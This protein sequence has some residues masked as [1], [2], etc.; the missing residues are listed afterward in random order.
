MKHKPYEQWLLDEPDL[1]SAQ[2]KE[3]QFHLES[4]PYCQQLNSNWQ[5]SKQLLSQAE[6]KIP[7]PGF[8]Q[9]WQATYA[10]KTRLEKVRRLRLTLLGMLLFALLGSLSYM[11][12]S[13]I[14]LQIVSNTFSG[15]IQLVIA[16]THGLSSLGIIFRS[17]PGFV[18]FTFGFMLFGLVNAFLMAAC[19]TLWNLKNRKMHPDEISIE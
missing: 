3:L 11:I 10:R 16:I 18:P 9:R 12:A 5:A 19:F 8:S 15:I 2:K 6:L 4:C 7:A 17:L 14:L 13:G 1:T